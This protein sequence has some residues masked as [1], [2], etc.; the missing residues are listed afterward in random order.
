M[1]VLCLV[2]RS[3]SGKTTFLENLLTR[4][5]AAGKKVL[6]IKSSHHATPDDP[7]SDSFRL[8]Q[9]GGCDTILLSPG[10]SHL[11]LDPAPDLPDLI[12][13][14]SSRD[15][16]AVLVEGGKTS[17]FPKVEL[18]CQQPPLL[19]EDQVLFRIERFSEGVAEKDV[20]KVWDYLFGGS[21]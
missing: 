4:S 3:G 18:V 9:A 6:A 20:L 14:L 13:W 10:G 21:R 8:A 15:Y 17:S 11:F 16:D 19:T 5:R 12:A 1:K 2:G 7:G